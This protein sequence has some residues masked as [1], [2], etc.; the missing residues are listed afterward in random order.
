MEPSEIAR[1][2]D[3]MQASYPNSKISPT[4]VL[5]LW[6]HK[7]ELR[8]FPNARRA[9]LVNTILE[10][11]KE[12][13]T[14]PELLAACQTIAPKPRLIRDTCL[15]CDDTGWIHYGRFHETPTGEMVWEPTDELLPPVHRV[16]V[17]PGCVD[18]DGQP[19]ARKEIVFEYQG[20]PIN[21]HHPRPCPICTH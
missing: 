10:R 19:I 2:L 14:M 3:T 5:D 1:L 9:D 21:Y 12:F 17:M 20:K 4:K 16:K 11:C 18:P 13:P 15:M 7:K 8:D 6:Q